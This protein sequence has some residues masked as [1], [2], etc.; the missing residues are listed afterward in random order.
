[1]SHDPV[2]LMTVDIR[3]LYSLPE[4][5]VGYARARQIRWRGEKE[6]IRHLMRHDQPFLELFQQCI[7]ETDR[8]RKVAL[9]EQTA[10]MA[11]APVGGLWASDATA[12]KVETGTIAPEMIEQALR[13]WQSLLDT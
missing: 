8:K 9:Y 6:L 3:L 5:L 1:M 11:L 7:A 2:Y 10:A 13:F 4:V 12:V